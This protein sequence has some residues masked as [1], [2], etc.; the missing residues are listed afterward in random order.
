M[1]HEF[2]SVT[3]L[4]VCVLFMLHDVYAVHCQFGMHADSMLIVISCVAMLLLVSFTLML[5]V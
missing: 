3:L 1:L 5:S 4:Q 2:V